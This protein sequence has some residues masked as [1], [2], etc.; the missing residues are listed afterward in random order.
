MHRREISWRD[1]KVT[2][3]HSAEYQ[4]CTAYCTEY[5]TSWSQRILATM[6]YMHSS[7]RLEWYS[8]V[9]FLQG[10]VILCPFT[11]YDVNSVP[12]CVTDTTDLEP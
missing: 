2:S 3:I 11:E 10:I 8:A 5:C 7:S 4:N 9:A 1:R 12:A 6:H